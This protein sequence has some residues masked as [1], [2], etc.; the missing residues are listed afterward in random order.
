MISQ[1]ITSLKSRFDPDIIAKWVI[2]VSPGVISATLTF[3]IFWLLYLILSRSL[4]FMLRKASLD[5]TLAAF[6][7]DL[8]KYLIIG[9]GILAS[10]NE[11]G[12]NTSSILGSLGVAG[13]T[14]GFAAKDTLSNLMAGLFLFWDRPFGVGDIVIISG[15]Y[16][17]ISEI[18]LRSTRIVTPDGKM[19]SFPN[20][21][22]VNAPLTS[23]TNFPNLQLTFAQTFPTVVEIANIRS[24][25]SKLFSDDE[26]FLDSPKPEV[27]IIDFTATTFKL[28]FTIWIRDETSHLVLEKLLKEKIFIN[29]KALMAV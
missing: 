25:F 16:G 24:D 1:I 15:N 10:L 26:R 21:N 19:I 2:S 9:S 17:R 18:T 4:S 6:F 5:R 8:L 12:L 7:E 29:F 27:N 14:I 13:L 11:L 28:E 20:S 22:V 3:L 23:Y